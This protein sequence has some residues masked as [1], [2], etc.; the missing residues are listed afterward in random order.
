[1]AAAFRGQAVRSSAPACAE[2]AIG[3]TVVVHGGDRTGRAQ[4]AHERSDVVELRVEGRS[5]LHE[6]DARLGGDVGEVKLRLRWGIAGA[7][8]AMVQDDDERDGGQE[9][10]TDDALA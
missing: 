2:V 1:P 8:R 10:N 9:R 5:V 3:P 6:V 7:G 4:R